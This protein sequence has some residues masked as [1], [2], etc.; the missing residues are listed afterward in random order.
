[1]KKIKSI[2]HLQKEKRRL[3]LR[4]LELEEE[5]QYNW[6]QFKDC[7]HP[8]SIAKDLFNT[9]FTQKP[10][11]GLSIRSIVKNAFV[12]GVSF[13]AKKMANKFDEKLFAD[14]LSKAER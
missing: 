10:E 8:V 9:A 4:Q 5:L 2:K 14:H 6:D 11:E 12:F 13:L 7:L 1:M 3:L